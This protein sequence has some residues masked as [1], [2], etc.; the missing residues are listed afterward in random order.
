MDEQL[1]R[2]LLVEDDPNFGTVLKDYLTMN[3]YEVTH[4]KNGMEGFEKFKRGDFDLCIL[5]VMMPYKDGFT[6]A[7]EI[8]E[9]N[10]DVPIVFLTAKAMKEDVLKGYKVGADDYLNKPFDSEVLLMKIKAIMQR[11]ANDSVA[12]SKQFEFK[13]GS[14]D[15]NSK[16]RFL[17]FK[18]EEPVKLSPK[19]NE[20]LRMLALHENDLMPRELALTKIWRDDNYF[21]S[22]SMD[23]YIAK[24]RKYLKP[25]P[26]VEI[27]NIH[28]EGFRLVV[29]Q[30]A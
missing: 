10:A 29:N 21:T 26:K 20:L 1:K 4:A 5:D 8:R 23:V 6:L 18:D 27:L 13:I 16:L 25:D 11:K 14:F 22:R 9:K 7:K 2:I 30:D 24:L 17:K 12:D 19:E 3:D 15:L 28:G